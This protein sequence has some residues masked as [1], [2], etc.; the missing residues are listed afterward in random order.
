MNILW[1]PFRYGSIRAHIEQG[2]L[3]LDLSVNVDTVALVES[4]VR[5]YRSEY[6][7]TGFWH[8]APDTVNAAKIIGVITCFM[9]V[10][11]YKIPTKQCLKCYI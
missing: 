4:N 9:G 10:G 2:I 5:K 1:P 8:Q 11:S 3:Q 6:S 7:I